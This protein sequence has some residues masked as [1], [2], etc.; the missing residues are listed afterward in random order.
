[1]SISYNIVKDFGGTLD[2]LVEE[3]VGTTFRVILPIAPEAEGAT[4]EEESPLDAPL[5]V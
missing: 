4:T 5:E 3:V 1:M 2:F